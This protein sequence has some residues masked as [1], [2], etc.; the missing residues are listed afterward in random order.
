MV[1]NKLAETMASSNSY[2]MKA[3]WGDLS[4]NPESQPK[5]TDAVWSTKGEAGSFDVIAMSVSKLRQLSALL[6]STNGH[7]SLAYSRLLLVDG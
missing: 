7:V 2:T 1:Y 4:C 5:M 3:L 6:N